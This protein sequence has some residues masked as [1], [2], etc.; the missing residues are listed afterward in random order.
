MH[1]MLYLPPRKGVKMSVYYSFYLGKQDGDKIVPVGPFDESGKLVPCLFCC[2]ETYG[3][4]D[5]F[6][7][8]DK[9]ILSDR[10]S[11]FDEFEDIYVCA[12][13]ELP[14]DSFI[15]SGYYLID[16]VERYKDDESL[17]YWGEIFYD[18]LSPEAYAAKMTSEIAVGP[19]SPYKDEFGNE[20]RPHSVSDYMYFSYID[21]ASKEYLSHEI[22]SVLD[23]FVV[24]PGSDYVV[25]MEVS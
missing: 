21:Y 11:N 2:G 8:T 7:K 24:N 17:I 5:Y 12:Y 23:L 10:F 14:N 1:W 3:L 25:I 6:I 15:K 4:R 20:I 13:N 16:D 18:R 9:S 22:K 19:P